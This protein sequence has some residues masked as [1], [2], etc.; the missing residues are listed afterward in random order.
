[1]KSSSLHTLTRD[2]LTWVNLTKIFNETFAIISII[3]LLIYEPFV[4]CPPYKLF[5]L[6]NQKGT[7]TFGHYTFCRDHH[8]S[9]RWWFYNDHIILPTSLERVR[10][11]GNIQILFYKVK[12]ENF[13]NRNPR[14]IIHGIIRWAGR[15]LKTYFNVYTCLCVSPSVYTDLPGKNTRWPN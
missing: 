15:L 1:M 9:N 11:K 5:G 2:G 7:T 3:S 4:C 6:C 8:D 10:S 12:G 14:N 13:T